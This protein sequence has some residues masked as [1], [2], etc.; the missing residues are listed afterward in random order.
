MSMFSLPSLVR[1]VIGCNTC[2]ILVL[3]YYVVDNLLASIID[4]H[5]ILP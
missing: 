5:C 2:R 1:R 4:N 3:L